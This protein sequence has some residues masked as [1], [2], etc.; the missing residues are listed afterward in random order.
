MSF[1]QREIERLNSAINSGLGERS[2]LYAAQQALSWAMEPG[3]IKSPYAMIMGTRVNSEDCLA[4]P[5]QPPSS[6]TCSQIG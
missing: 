3:G 1:M 2:E 4:H 5:H 6:D